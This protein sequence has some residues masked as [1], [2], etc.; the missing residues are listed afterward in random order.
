MRDAFAPLTPRGRV[1]V[2]GG[3]TAAAC[4][5]VLGLPALLRVGLFAAL[6]PLVVLA[7]FSRIDY[8]ISLSRHVSPPRVACGQPAV[9]TLRVHNEGAT[10]PG[11]LLVEDSVGYALGARPRIRLDRLP[12]GAEHRHEYRV[13]SDVRGRHVLGPATLRVSDPLGLVEILRSFRSTTPLVVL[14]PLVDLGSVRPSSSVDGGSGG[15]D[16][17]S[18]LSSD[19]SGVRAYRRGDDVRRVHWRSSA[20]LGELMVRQEEHPSRPASTLLLDVRSG[21]HR[22]RGAAS[23]F[24]TAV[25]AV[26]SVLVHLHQIGHDVRLVTGTEHLVIPCD[27][28]DA[29]PRALDHLAVVS[30]VDTPLLPAWSGSDA[31]SARPWTIAVL[32]TLSPVDETQL[33]TW[34][35]RSGRCSALVVDA[36]EWAGGTAR[37]TD[38]RGTGALLPIPWRS[39]LLGPRTSI[40]SAWGEVA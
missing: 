1:L 31:P 14:P 13:S 34:T 17:I 8:R 28:P 3:A 23:S 24:E 30:L 6:L 21:A 26:A 35:A 7:V 5:V 19:E 9:V 32:G 22:G 11:S 20:R 27:D 2:V 39:A 15:R 18:H 4:G 12:R 25:R 40:A 37:G 29:L 16:V 33:A 36:D 10:P 38:R